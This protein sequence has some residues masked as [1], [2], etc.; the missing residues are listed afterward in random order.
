ML[1]VLIALAAVAGFQA[2]GSHVDAKARAE[3]DCVATLQCN[4]APGAATTPDAMVVKHDGIMPTQGGPGPWHYPAKVAGWIWNGIKGFVVDGLW[5]DLKGLW[6]LVTDLPGTVKGLWQLGKTVFFGSPVLPLG[7]PIPNPWRDP[8]ATEEL[9]Q[10][11]WALWDATKEYFTQTPDRAVGRVVYEVVTFVVAPAKIL[12]ATKAK[13]LAKAGKAAKVEDKLAE[14]SKIAKAEDKLDDAADA[15]KVAKADEAKAAATTGVVKAVTKMPGDQL[16]LDSLM[17]LVAESDG[18]EDYIRKL[19][20]R[21]KAD[22]IGTFYAIHGDQTVTPMS[23][24]VF[25]T[26]GKATVAYA[27]QMYTEVLWSQG[28][29]TIQFQIVEE[30]NKKLSINAWRFD[31]NNGTG[32]APMNPTPEHLLTPE[33]VKAMHTPELVAKTN[34]YAQVGCSRCHMNVRRRMVEPDNHPRRLQEDPGWVF[35]DPE[36][37]AEVSEKMK[38]MFDQ[39]A[40]GPTKDNPIYKW[41]WEQDAVVERG[42]RILPEDTFSYKKFTEDLIEVNGEEMLSELRRNPKWAESRKAFAAAVQDGEQADDLLKKL[43]GYDG[44]AL[45]ADKAAVEKMHA[46][47]NLAWIRKRNNESIA[48]ILAEGKHA[49]VPQFE[50]NDYL[51]LNRHSIETI[52]PRI[53]E[54]VVSDA[55]WAKLSEAERATKVRLQDLDVKDMDE[56]RAVVSDPKIV[57]RTRRRTNTYIVLN[58]M[59]NNKN[60]SLAHLSASVRGLSAETGNKDI[61]LLDVYAEGMKNPKGSSINRPEEPLDMTR[62]P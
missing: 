30:A 18:Y 45:A 39:F 28:G 7:A 27:P 24:Q 10:I 46:E 52:G 61:D 14:V 44:A 50:A 34:K 11:G 26:Y 3:A 25:A 15:A 1:V 59:L 38:G 40:N 60:K 29:E 13:W 31:V 53:E 9:K 35:R 41:F 16:T 17:D 51:K 4:D 54:M 19:T 8:A 56:L 2:L 36:Q 49:K 47:A 23:P 57:E 42:G 21:Y 37:R 5:G 55:D 48:F 62:K 33:A 6:D 43:K 58:H 12:K 20:T 22:N 32:K